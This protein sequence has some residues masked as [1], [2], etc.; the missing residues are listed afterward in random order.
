MKIYVAVEDPYNPK[1]NPYV[2]TL[3]DG[4]NNQFTDVQ[5]G[6]GIS[7]FWNKECLSYDIIHIH[8]PH[9]L[10]YRLTHLD[11]FLNRIN[12]L[13]SKGIK[14]ISTCHNLEPHYS[15]NP[16]LKEVYDIVY[17]KSDC[18]L[19]LGKYSLQLFLNKYPL[20]DNQLLF[21]HVYDE[22][23]KDLPSREESLEFLNLDSSKFYVLCFGAFRSKEE[24]DFIIDLANNLKGKNIEIL[25]PSFYR[26]MKRRNILCLLKSYLYYY[27]YKFRYKNIKFKNEFIDDTAL[28]FYYGAA[29]VS[30]IHRL[31]ILNSGNVPLGFLMK[32]III[33]PQIGN[34]GRWLEETG[35]FT[36][37]IDKTGEI[38]K[39]VDYIIENKIDGEKNYKYAIDYLSTQKISFQLYQHYKRTLMK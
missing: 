28:K 13:K 7:I 14:L 22:I 16:I 21:H 18:I 20:V 6:W 17:E 35:N 26:L 5:W 38:A 29:S 8:W 30:L 24:R 15:N 33:G 2:R 37:K 11:T 27:Y 36:F 12:Y 23:Y 4:I 1:D 32:K 39:I 25:A 34:V 3:I 9:Y 19:H 10:C 31:K